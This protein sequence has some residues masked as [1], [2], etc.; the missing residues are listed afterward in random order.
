MSKKEAY[1]L[2]IDLGTSG[3]KVALTDL[4]G[5]IIGWKF[6]PTPVVLL[7]NGGA[8]QDTKTWWQAI[9]NA[10][11]ALF[12]ETGINGDDVT[13]VSCTAQWSGTVAVNANGKALMNAII[14]MDSRG[15]PYIHQITGGKLS[16]DGYAVNKAIPW[17]RKTGGLP[18]RAGKDPTAHIL[19]IKHQFPEIYAQTHKFLEPKDYLN[20]KLTG[21]FAASYDS[22]ALHWVTDNRDPANVKY[23]EKL[24]Q[25]AGLDIDKL[26]PLFPAHTILDTVTAKAAKKLGINPAAKV[27]MGTPDVQSAALGSGAVRDFQAHL[28]IG[29]SA[30]LTCHVPFK[31]TDILHNM[32]SLPSPIPGRYFIAN[33]QETAGACLNFLRDK[34]FPHPEILVEETGASNIYE[35]FDKI[36]AETPAGS[37]GVIF[38]PWLY[39]ERTPVENNT[40]RGGF[41][42]VS[43]Q[44]DYRHFVRAVFEGVAFNARWLLSA[45]ENFSKRRFRT[46]NI[47]GGGANSDIWCQIHA[48]I[49]NRT[50]RQVED[51]ILANIR[52]A[53]ILAAVALEQG[54]FEKLGQQVHIKKTYEPNE[55]NLAIYDELFSEFINIYKRTHPIYARLNRQ[56]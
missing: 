9:L 34:L 6:E 36:V 18:G 29:T 42:N 16:V 43:L 4:S 21:K 52:G 44:S 39:G 19:T 33:E 13:A 11:R 48:D 53:S 27:V 17:I 15:A 38:T 1:T 46:I 8:E 22:I 10:T 56:K 31:K 40:I 50:I 23:D 26:P 5:K 20:L 28:Y 24:L 7:D 30:W 45:V 54:S 32:A 41:F 49:L 51:P 2:I 12:E 25:L 14:W 35:A 3:P 37:G 47:I 55:N